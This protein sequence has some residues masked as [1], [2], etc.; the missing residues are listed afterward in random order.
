MT[1]A[2]TTSLG[3]PKDLVEE[4]EGL[5]KRNGWAY[6]PRRK[7]SVTKLLQGRDGLFLLAREGLSFHRLG[8]AVL[9]FHPDTAILR[10][11][12]P[13][14][15]LRTLLGT[16][17]KTILDTTMGLATD[18][19]VMAQA[20]HQVTAVESQ[21]LIAQVVAYGLAHYESGWPSFDAA[22][23]SIEVVHADHLAFLGEQAS[24]AFDIVYCDPMFSQTITES[25]NLAGI[26]DLANANQLTDT[27]MREACRVAK[28]AVIFKGHFRDKT[29]ERLGFDRQVRPNQKFHYGIYRL[30]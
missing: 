29:F 6:L 24:N 28:E 20:G 21:N 17:P 27:F 23:R 25:H 15:P 19:I 22:M 4:A 9:Q 26:A 5:A 16:S 18:A 2:I 11:K 1:L 7:Y 30:V 10:A 12:A 14:D 8:Q 13:H 3:M